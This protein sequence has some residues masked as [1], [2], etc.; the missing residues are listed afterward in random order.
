M[1]YQLQ[2][3]L[4]F[5]NQE[6]LFKYTC[7]YISPKFEFDSSF[8]N[9]NKCIECRV[10]EL[11]IVIISEYVGFPDSYHTT[12]DFHPNSRLYDET[13]KRISASIINRVILKK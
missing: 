1:K 10:A 4:D 5:S 7:C 2:E 6:V 9:V 12:G 13:V 3:N 8:K 11:D